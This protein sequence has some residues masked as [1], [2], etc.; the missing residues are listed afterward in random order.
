MP[1]F[2]QVERPDFSFF[3][4]L[5]NNTLLAFWPPKSRPLLV[6]MS[7]E[8]WACSQHWRFWV[9]GRQWSGCHILDDRRRHNVYCVLHIVANVA[10]RCLYCRVYSILWIN[11]NDRYSICMYIYIYIIFVEKNSCFGNPGFLIPCRL[12]MSLCRH[13]RPRHQWEWRQG[14]MKLQKTLVV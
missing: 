12:C 13:L 11:V 5:V 10:Y 7:Y 6:A 2:L 8:P 4:S 1:L 14:I 9:A 3:F